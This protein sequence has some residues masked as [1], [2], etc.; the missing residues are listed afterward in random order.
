MPTKPTLKN[1][2]LHTNTFIPYNLIIKLLDFFFNNSLKHLF[3]F[4]ANQ[5]EIR[6]ICHGTLG[7]IYLKSMA[8]NSVTN[9]T[10]RLKAYMKNSLA[11]NSLS[12][13]NIFRRNIRQNKEQS[14]MMEMWE[15][16]LTFTKLEF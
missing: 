7:F 6:Y 4:S 1:G 2:S 8:M 14:T 12:Q 15:Y 9:R 5:T 13:P 16:Y 11:H 3:I 10:G